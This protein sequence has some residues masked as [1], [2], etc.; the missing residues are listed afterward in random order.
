MEMRFLFLFASPLLVVPT[1]EMMRFVEHKKV[2]QP[3][4]TSADLFA[5]HCPPAITIAGEPLF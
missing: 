2:D 5:Q 1:N 4:R 3:N